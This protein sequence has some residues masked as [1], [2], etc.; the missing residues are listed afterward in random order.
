MKRNYNI[1]GFE[2]FEN[3]DRFGNEVERSQS[4]HPYSYDPF[5]TFRNGEN[6]EINDTVYSDR[7][8]QWNPQKY[9]KLK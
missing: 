1:F 6:E 7:L 5:V 3:I 8:F 9:N 2:C 4:S